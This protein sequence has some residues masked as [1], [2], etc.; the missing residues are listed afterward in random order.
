[1]ID[2]ESNPRPRRVSRKQ[3]KPDPYIEA[4]TGEIRGQH[5]DAQSLATAIA[6]LKRVAE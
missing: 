2:R 5:F 6:A 4:H 3:C 1:M